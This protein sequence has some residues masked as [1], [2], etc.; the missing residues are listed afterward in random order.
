MGRLIARLIAA[1][2]RMGSAARGLQ[3]PLA[4]R[5]VPTDPASQGLPQRRLA[6]PPAPLG[7]HGHPDRV[8]AGHVV[9]DLLGQPAAADVALVATILFMLAA[10]ATG[11]RRLHRHRRH[12]A[13]ARDTPLDADGRGAAS[14]SSSRS[15]SA[16][17][18]PA[19][20]TIPIALSV[21]GFLI[22]TAGAYVG[23]DVVYLFGN[24]VSRH[25]FRGA[26]TKWIKLDTGDVDR[27]RDASR[28][29]PDQGA[30][31]A[32][33]TSS[34]SGSPT[35]STPSTRSAR[36]PADRSRRARSSTA[37]SSARGTARGSG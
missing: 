14:C 18:A 10:A 19:D 25:A 17:A 6:R 7:R 5:P 32:S 29:D 27:P 21:I 26:G 2:D 28:G 9:L 4:E 31:P 33:T 22:V 11:C 8:A 3:P 30:G 35:R 34:S 20:R 36:T 23:G 13:H 37:A 15:H 24:M 1:Q 12:G 16:P